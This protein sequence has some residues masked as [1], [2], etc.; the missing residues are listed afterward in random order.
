M[1]ELPGY[2]LEAYLTWAYKIEIVGKTTLTQ[3]DSV[4]MRPVITEEQFKVIV[5]MFE[6]YRKSIQS[7]LDD[8]DEDKHSWRGYAGDA[9]EYLPDILDDAVN[10]A[11]GWFKN[12]EPVPTT[13]AERQWIFFLQPFLVEL[14]KKVAA[15]KGRLDY[16]NEVHVKSIISS[17][18][19]F[20]KSK[21]IMELMFSVGQVLGV[22]Y[23]EREVEVVDLRVKYNPFAALFVAYEEFETEQLK[24]R[25]DNITNL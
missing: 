4:L 11:L 18:Q 8:F 13:Q 10:V 9:F 7:R 12:N 6:P 2:T 3:T 19:A 16:K 1:S 17:L 22:L 14:E 5:E 20:G 15:A 23:A 24:S 25:L 21:S